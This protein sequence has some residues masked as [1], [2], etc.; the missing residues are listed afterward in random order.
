MNTVLEIHNQENNKYT[1]F[2]LTSIKSIKKIFPHPVHVGYEFEINNFKYKVKNIYV[3]QFMENPGFF[4]GLDGEVNAETHIVFC[5]S[6]TDERINIE[7]SDFS[8]YVSF[9][10]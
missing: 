4:E 7:S 1:G 9:F 2:K 3:Y 10:Q 8:D 6:S 5:C